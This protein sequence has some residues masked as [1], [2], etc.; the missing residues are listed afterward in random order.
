MEKQVRRFNIC[1]ASKQLAT[2]RLAN[3]VL[4]GP[5]ACTNSSMVSVGTVSPKLDRF[6]Q[7]EDERKA[8]EA[9]K[10]QRMLERR[11]REVIRD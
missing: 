2:H 6:E 11:S 10:K 3:V 8:R 5:L 9:A 7:K 1:L 4:S